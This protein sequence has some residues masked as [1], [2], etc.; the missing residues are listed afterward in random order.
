M[1]KRTSMIDDTGEV[2]ELTAADLRHFKPAE[3]ALSPRL[4]ADLR[5]LNRRA[6]VR[7]A[8]K[9]PTKVLTTIR[10][11][12]DVMEAFRATGPGWQTRMD[13]ALRDWLRTHTPAP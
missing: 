11:S 9:A 10:L 3:Q 2:R 13:A 12:P 1:S 7:G 6:G 5:A 8:Q 4:Y